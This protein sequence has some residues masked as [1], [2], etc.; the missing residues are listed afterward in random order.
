MKKKRI[1]ISIS[2]FVSLFVIFISFL[3]WNYYKVE[4]NNL[5]IIQEFCGG[6]EDYQYTYLRIVL[7]DELYHNEKTLNAIKFY[8]EKERGR[9]VQNCLR[10]VLYSDWN[11]F[12][13]C[14]EYED[15]TFNKDE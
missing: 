13:E 8:I 1:I 9:G 5:K 14:K 4:M 3:Y 11:D 6:D 12:C 2:I 15:Y 10:I 7:P